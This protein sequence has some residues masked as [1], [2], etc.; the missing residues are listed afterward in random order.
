[1]RGWYT[2]DDGSSLE[3]QQRGQY[4]SAGQGFGLVNLDRS[5]SFAG[6]PLTSWFHD[7]YRSSAES[8]DVSGG[9]TATRTYPITGRVGRAARTSRS[10][11]PTRPTRCRR[12]RPRSSTTCELTLTDPNGKVYVGNNFNA[13][14]EPV[15][16]GR[17][18]T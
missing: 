6:G 8:F 16:R 17:R 9:A 12:V 13:R 5:L 11:G 15:G 1:M 7:V 14:T 2:G 10:R 3:A 18:G 4:P